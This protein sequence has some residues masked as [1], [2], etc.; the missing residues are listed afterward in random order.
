MG[1]YLVGWFWSAKAVTANTSRPDA[2][3]SRFGERQDNVAE[4]LA[5]KRLF[6]GTLLCMV[7]NFCAGGTPPEFLSVLEDFP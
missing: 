5:Q 2:A 3:E 7:L 6:Q 1:Q 4:L